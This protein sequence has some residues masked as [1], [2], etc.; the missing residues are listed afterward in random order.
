MPGRITA[1]KTQ[2][3]RKD[4]VSI[5]LDGEYAFSLQDILAA[6]LRH[7][8]ELSEQDIE[9]LTQQDAVE[10]AYEGALHYLSFRPRSE[11]EMRRYLQ[12]RGMGDEGTK[13]VLDRLRRAGLV[14]DSEFVRFWVE[15]REAH[16][17]RGVVALRAELR[18]KGV[19]DEEIALALTGVDEEANAMN[20]ARQ[21]AHRLARLGEDL[22]RRRLLGYLQRRG[23]GYEVARRVA[24]Q[25]WA[26]ITA[27]G[28]TDSRE[29]A[30]PDEH[31][32]RNSKEWE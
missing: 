28:E 8:Q 23:F 27:Q 21:V 26:E 14:R 4:R 19:S 9:K 10:A 24:D 17:P 12:K 30:L 22:Y 31:K 3:R 16:R 6:G 2:E 18:R 20:A 13:Q 1:I 11:D 29:R 7:G 32:E 5:F 25:L 15:N